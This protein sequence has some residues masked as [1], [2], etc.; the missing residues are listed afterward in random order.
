MNGA[1]IG[2]VQGGGGTGLSTETLQRLR[3]LRYGFREK[4]E[5]DE[6]AKVSVLGLVDH[7][8]STT[9]ELLQDA[10]VRDGLANHRRETVLGEEC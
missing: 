2:V 4:F 6:A 10:V 8:H 9:A 3:V 5:S 1:D 7:T